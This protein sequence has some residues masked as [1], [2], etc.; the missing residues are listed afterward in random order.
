MVGGRFGVVFGPLS[1]HVM[2]LLL[3]GFAPIRV[4]QLD[5]KVIQK[6]PP[7]RESALFDAKCTLHFYPREVYVWGSKN[8]PFLGLFLGQFWTYFWSIFDR[9]YRQL[10]TFGISEGDQILARFLIEKGV[11]SGGAFNGSPKGKVLFSLPQKSPY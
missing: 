9:L 1:E 4:S 10:P 2:G 11:I 7:F 5:Q 3:W 6:G 8:D